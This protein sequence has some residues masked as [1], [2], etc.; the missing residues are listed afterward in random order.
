MR[1]ELRGKKVKSAQRGRNRAED[2]S[3][4]RGVDCKKVVVVTVV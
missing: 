1:K 4:G 2:R 3:A